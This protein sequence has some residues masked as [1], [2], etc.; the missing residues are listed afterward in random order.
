MYTKKT[1]KRSEIIAEDMTEKTHQIVCIKL[2]METIAK[3]KKIAKS[4]GRL[5]SSFIAQAVERS[6]E[7]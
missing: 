2:P 1:K 5:F 6:A 4:Q 3:L 7:L